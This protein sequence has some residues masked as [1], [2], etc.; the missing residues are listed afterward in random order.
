MEITVVKTI[1]VFMIPAGRGDF[2]IIKYGEKDQEHYIFIDGGDKSGVLHYVVVLKRLREQGKKIDAM[3]FTH[4]DNDHLSGALSAIGAMDELPEIG[5]IYM[6]TG[7]GI[8]KRFGYRADDG[9]PEDMPRDYIHEKKTTHT[10]RKALS[11]LELFDQKGLSDKIEP[12]TCQGDQLNIGPA[13]LRVISPGSDRLEEYLKYW[14][15]E[16]EKNTRRR[17]RTHSVIKEEPVRALAEYVGNPIKEDCSVTN[18]SAIAFLFEYDGHRL[19]F[20]GDTWPSECVA[21][22]DGIEPL[23]VDFI[24]I[25]HHGSEHNYSRE[26]YDRLRTD[27]FLLSTKG[28][29]HHPSPVFLGNLFGQ[30]PNATIYC[31]ENWLK[32]YHFIKSDRERYCM[33]PERQIRILVKEETITEGVS[34]DNRISEI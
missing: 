12:C 28:T 25:P 27:K 21:G 31:N 8:E 4:I 7:R 1:K 15:A 18:G 6:N 23:D 29:S 2:F 24:K 11:L 32:T 3:I 26:L 22:L 20:L 30:V 17:M 14:R 13:I 10:V 9:Y 34:L 5:K 19:A 16:E 33:G